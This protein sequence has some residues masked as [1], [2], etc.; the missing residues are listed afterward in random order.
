MELTRAVAFYGGEE[1]RSKAPPPWNSNRH[2]IGVLNF[3]I[4]NSV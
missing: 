1:P 2:S 4:W 3:F